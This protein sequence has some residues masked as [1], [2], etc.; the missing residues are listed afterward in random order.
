[1]IVGDQTWQV[2]LNQPQKQP[3][4]VLHIPIFGLLVTNFTESQIQPL[5]GYG[6][7]GYGVGGYGT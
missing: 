6:V 3:L 5:G 7:T 4:Y 2:K 1:M